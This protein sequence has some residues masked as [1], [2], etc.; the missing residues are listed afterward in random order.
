MHHQSISLPPLNRPI[1]P[2]YEDAARRGSISDS[3]YYLSVAQDSWHERT[4]GPRVKKITVYVQ[5]RRGWRS[6]A[7]TIRETLAPYVAT[8]QAGAVEVKG[9]SEPMQDGFGIGIETAWG[10]TIGPWQTI[11]QLVAPIVNEG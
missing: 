3:T 10:T 1:E 9:S 2:W 11:Y 4:Y 5:K 6:L 8:R 7:R